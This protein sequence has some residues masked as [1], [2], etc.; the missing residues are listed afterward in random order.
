MAIHEQYRPKPPEEPQTWQ[1][2]RLIEINPH[3]TCRCT[4]Y[5]QNNCLLH[6]SHTVPLLPSCAVGMKAVSGTASAAQAPMLRLNLEL[7]KLFAADLLC[8]TSQHAA[9]VL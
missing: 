5:Q 3:T 6:P 9:T 1:P 4:A 8:I 2:P 7:A